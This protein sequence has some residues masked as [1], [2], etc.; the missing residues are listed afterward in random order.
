MFDPHDV[1]DKGLQ[2]IETII[3]NSNYCNANQQ[4]TTTVGKSSNIAHKH[5]YTHE[6]IKSILSGLYYDN[7]FCNEETGDDCIPDEPPCFEHINSIDSLW[8][9]GRLIYVASKEFKVRSSFAMNLICSR[10]IKQGHSGILYL[11]K[12]HSEWVAR[13]LLSR[14]S[15][16]DEEKLRQ[17]SKGPVCLTS[18]EQSLINENA[19]LLKTSNLWIYNRVFSLEDIQ[20]AS[21]CF[22]RDGLNE[23]PLELIIVDNVKFILTYGKETFEQF[24]DE[25]RIIGKR[26]DCP[27]LLLIQLDYSV[28][29]P[30]RLADIDNLSIYRYINNFRSG[31]FAV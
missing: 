11:H 13:S 31:Y 17:F 24:T 7:M 29:K 14:L 18:A 23:K 6:W 25:L 8:Y 30:E 4:E 26:L 2:R 12:S 1:P 22:S 28:T 16:I 9:P 5:S 15:G 20:Y 19:E 10:I 3:E 21:D 27:I